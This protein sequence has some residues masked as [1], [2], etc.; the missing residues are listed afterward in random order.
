MT[1]FNTP[2]GVT[3]TED[4]FSIGSPDIFVVHPDANTSFAFTS[5]PG[6]T[7]YETPPGPPCPDIPF[8]G[9]YWPG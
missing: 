6:F 3:A 7:A 2:P 4:T 1:A 5:P 8:I 9:Q